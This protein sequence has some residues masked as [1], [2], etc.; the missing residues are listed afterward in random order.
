MYELYEIAKNSP[1]WFTYFKTVEDTLH[2]SLDDINKDIAS[3]EIS[4]DM[5]RQE[6]FCS[7]EM[8]QEGSLYA[9]YIQNMRLRGQIGI[10]PWEPY[11]KVYTSWDLGIADPTCIIFFQV[12]GELVRIIDYYEQSDRAM[13]HFAKVVLEKPYVYASNGHFP[14]HDIMARESARGL[15]KREMYKELGI[16]FTEPVQI[17]IEDGIELVRRTFSKMWIDEKNCSKLIKALENYRYEWDDKLKRYKNNPRHDNWSHGSDAMR[18]L[19]AAL[20]KC[21]SG[22]NAEDLEKRY[23]EAMYG[24][25]SR[26]SGPFRE[27]GGY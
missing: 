20:P 21:R 14:P 18:Y 19:C 17:D 16:K 11:H 5:A 26:F 6:Y 15:T 13:D 1:D 8:G 27:D 3:G 12:I 10:V 23:Q 9:K 2:I 7:W 22:S 4:Q 24:Q 25:Q